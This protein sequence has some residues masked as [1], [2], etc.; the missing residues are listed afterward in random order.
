MVPRQQLLGHAATVIVG[1]QMH[2]L[3]DPQV[4]EQSLLQVGLL[5]QAVG[6]I[7]RFGRIA[8]AQH[9]AGNHPEALGQGPPQVVPVP[10]GSGEAV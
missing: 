10:A 9:V 2:R 8:K 6:V 1:Q 3:V 4:V 7:D 5:H